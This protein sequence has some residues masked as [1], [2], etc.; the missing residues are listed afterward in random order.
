MWLVVIENCLSVSLS[1]S[2]LSFFPGY[3]NRVA[4]P[5]SVW[6]FRS[7]MS[8]FMVTLCIIAIPYCCRKTLPHTVELVISLN[9]HSLSFLTSLMWNFQHG[10]HHHHHHVPW[11][12]VPER[13]KWGP[14][15]WPASAPFTSTFP[16]KPSFAIFY[17]HVFAEISALLMVGK[18]GVIT[19]RIFIAHECDATYSH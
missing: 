3:C 7:L 5:C 1:G 8:S 14:V 11:L 10:H 6:H 19:E 15:S 12:Q 16:Q 18:K 4:F 13:S 17:V 2:Q 9:W